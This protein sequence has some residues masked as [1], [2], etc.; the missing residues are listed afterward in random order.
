VL[1]ALFIAAVS[2]GP[3][4]NGEQHPT[5]QCPEEDIAATQC[6]GPKD[7]LY[8]NPDSCESFIHC[9]VNAD[10]T[11]GR[12][13]I[14][15]CPSGLEWNDNKKECDYPEQSTCNVSGNS[16]EPEEPST[17]PAIDDSTTESD[18]S[19]TE[20]QETTT[21]DESSSEQPS[22]GAPSTEEPSSTEGSGSEE[23]TTGAS[24]EETTTEGSGDETTTGSSEEETTTGASNEETTTAGA[25][26]ETTTEE[27][28]TTA[29]PE[30]TT[31]EQQST[32]QEPTTA[33]ATST[34]AQ[35]TEQTTEQTST[36]QPTTEQTTARPSTTESS[37]GSTE[38][39]CPEE[40]IAATQ[41]MGPKDCLYPNPNSCTTFIHCEVN[42]DG[43][44][45]RPTIK[46]C[47]SGLQWN[48][49]KK[50]CDWPQSSTCP[51][52]R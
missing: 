43:K 8:P 11:S 18:D 34:T 1:L 17:T 13:T 6:K 23:T 46:D 39:V 26:D 45:G 25:G 7:C 27:P 12:P 51:D 20:G 19:T 14:Q 44:T 37:G 40:D 21:E 50:E 42:A 22:T 49:N 16:T 28:T 41:C 9:E 48:D 5:F 36:A 2:A 3:I 24:G 47:P 38:F 35:T 10:G 29:Q 4:R 30:E 32:T 15:D 31:T 52:R 33:E